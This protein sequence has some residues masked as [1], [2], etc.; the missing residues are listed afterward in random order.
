METES[1]FVFSSGGGNPMGDGGAGDSRQEPPD[2]NGGS[3]VSFR[4]K[5]VGPRMVEVVDKDADLVQQ[6]LFE[7]KLDDGNRLLPRCYVRPDILHRVC[8]PWKDTLVVRLLGKNVGFRT[9]SERLR[10]LW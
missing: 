6:G 2:K 4:D 3:Q 9:M 1:A 5:L 10:S 8:E 7:I